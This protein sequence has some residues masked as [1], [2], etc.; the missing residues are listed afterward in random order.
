MI[1][2]NLHSLFVE[3][4]FNWEVNTVRLQAPYKQAVKADARTQHLHEGYKYVVRER[5]WCELAKR[6]DMIYNTLVEAC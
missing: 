2:S 3:A 1:E 5:D 4:H 6:Y